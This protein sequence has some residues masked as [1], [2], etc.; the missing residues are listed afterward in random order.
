[1]LYSQMRGSIK[2]GDLLIWNKKRIANF[3]DLFLFLYQKIFNTKFSHVGIAIVFG[4]RVFVLEANPPE[5]RLIPLSMKGDFYYLPI[6]Y[7]WK[8]EYDAIAFTHIG[9]PYSLWNFI[10]DILNLSI[11]KSSTYCSLLAAEIY[12]KIG[13]MP[14]EDMGTEPK[15]LVDYLIKKAGLTE[16]SLQ[17]IVIDKG[18]LE[19][20]L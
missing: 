19:N 17:L 4:D 3:V 1:M 18:N 11:D 20:G 15:E 2:T 5:V 14:E 12:R 10:R 8:P 9:E 6:N 7:E 16:D 13:Y